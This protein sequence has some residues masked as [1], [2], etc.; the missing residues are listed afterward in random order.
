MILNYD[1]D[2]F[3][4]RVIDNCSNFVDKIYISYSKLPW[5]YNKQARDSYSNSSDLRILTKSPH[6]SKIEV[7]EGVWDTEEDQRNTCLDI[8]RQQGFEYLIVQDADE[9]YHEEAYQKN[10]SEI[11]ENPDYAYYTTNW[12]N[13]WKGLD[14]V[15]EFKDPGFGE[16]D[17]IH[18]R[19]ANFAV[20]LN[21]DTRFVRKRTIN[22]QDK[23][24]HLSGICHHLSYALSDDQVLRK[25]STWG[26][27]H[28]VNAS[29]WYRWKWLAWQPSTKYLYPIISV[30][31]NRAVPYQGAIPQQLADFPLLKHEYSELS[32]LDSIKCWF[33]DLKDMGIFYYR[34][35]IVGLRR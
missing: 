8:A 13:Y 5:M 25:I 31:A 26:H 28:Q 11:L 16:K 17:T 9:F 15:L 14:Y 18:S 12:I 21:M 6:F 32:L 4:L 19:C 30:T 27:A 7:I 34:K 3:I 1:C 35:M 29:N 22:F 24:M 10:L 33:S 2:Q 20:N 23:V